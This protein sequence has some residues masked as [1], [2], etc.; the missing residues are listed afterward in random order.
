MK[1]IIGLVG[2]KGS[3]KGTFVKFLQEIEPKSSSIRYS[4]ILI[5]TLKLWSLPLTRS[6]LQSLA[7]VMDKEYGNGTLA[8][9]VK[10]RIQSL[11]GDIV[12]V[13]GIRRWP[14]AEL[15]KSFPNHLIIYVTAD[16]K[17]RYQNLNS[18]SDKAEEA[19]LSM[20]QFMK[21]EADEAEMLI[22]EIGKTADF[23]ITNNGT[24]EELKKQVTE[25]MPRLER[26]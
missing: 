24:L 13:D 1:L 21:E 11:T 25:I 8:N 7:T 10:P 14:E 15:I 23:K 12:I 18:K 22:P 9:A 20:E 4:D 16:P 17:T 26:I 5:E 6:N 19:G 3:G 2:E